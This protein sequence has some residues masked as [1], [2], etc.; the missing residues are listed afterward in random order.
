MNQAGKIISVW[1][2]RDVTEETHDVY[3]RI[4]ELK[5]DCFCT[6]FPLRV[7]GIEQGPS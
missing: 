5:I 7:N 2:D 6:D 1:I 4:M 3:Q